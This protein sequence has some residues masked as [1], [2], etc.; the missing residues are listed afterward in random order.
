MLAAALML[1]ACSSTSAAPEEPPCVPDT[2]EPNEG[3]ANANA[4]G[5]IQ[6]DADITLPGQPSAEASPKKIRKT[7]SLHDGADVDWFSVDVL[8]TG[9]GGNPQLSVIMGDGVEATVF[10]S[11]ST[12]ATT[13]VCGLGTKV[14]DDPDV[15]GG[16]GCKTAKSEGAPPQLTMSFECDGTSS[17]DGRLEIRVKR[18]TPETTCLRY[19]LTVAAE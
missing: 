3:R 13:V 15:R 19:N 10:A 12:G 17:D 14:T 1:T 11:C 16:L 5:S 2:T 4:L 7:F 9:A 6:D 18:S 8:D